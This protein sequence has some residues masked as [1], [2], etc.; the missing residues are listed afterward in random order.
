MSKNRELRRPLFRSRDD[1]VM[2]LQY[3]ISNNFVNTRFT[4]NYAENNLHF[5]Q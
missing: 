4:V 3:A 1:D 5:Y 2:I